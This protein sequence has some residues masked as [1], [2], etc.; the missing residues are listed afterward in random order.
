MRTQLLCVTFLTLLAAACG[1]VSKPAGPRLI[2]GG[3]VGD[4]KISG[5][6][7]VYVTDDDTR[8][9]VSSAAVRVGGSADPA[10]CQGL[11]NSTGLVIFDATSCPSLKGPVT[12]TASAGGYAPSTWI[13]VDGTNVTVPIRATTRPDVDTATVS[14]TIAGWD[15]L[16]APATNH[17]TLALIGASQSPDL[18]D[19]AN[20]ITQGMRTVD[21]LGGLTT[22]DIPAN[23]CVRSAL[24]D[25]C[26]WQLT[27]RTGAQ[28]HFAIVI[29]QDTKGT[30]DETDDTNTVIG[31][32]I[33]TGLNFS[34]GD[35]A[36]GEALQMIADA[37]MQPVTAS[38]ATLPSGM[39][40][41]ASYP[42]L[43]LGAEGRI[44][45][46]LPVL[47][48][49]H[50]ATRVPKPA[51]ALAGAT[52]DLIG[53]AQGAK[54]QPAPASLAWLRH[55]NIAATVA[56][57]AWMPPPAALSTAGGTFSFSPVA[58]ATLHSAELLG[59]TGERA[60]SVTIFDGSTS[61][62]LPGLSP[63]PV[64]IGTVRF[65]VSALQIPGVELTAVQFDDAK[66]LLT[67][68]SS[69]Q[70]TYTH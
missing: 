66:D 16:P 28:A 62:T 24:A 46:I 7:N 32:A 56:I 50:T 17:Q 70:V 45:I 63:D 52:Y 54:D 8:T 33:K 35:A 43:E 11:T 49:T 15:T 39:S 31:W 26:S 1:D 25:D 44:P 2:P 58:G 9:P 27:T 13:G 59:A 5:T 41:V 23:V 6:L 30:T 64:P 22:A 47:D 21:V 38:F 51:G 42:M 34:A 61:F 37:D 67:A 36:S 12:L 68:I 18:G 65:S 29:D 53:Q 55:V 4:G 20:N 69:D 57:A 19:R 10:A 60:W 40:F 14:G 48:L 3:G